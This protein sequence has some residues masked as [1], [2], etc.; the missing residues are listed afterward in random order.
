MT[1]FQKARAA[2]DKTRVIDWDFGD[3]PETVAITDDS[4]FHIHAYPGLEA[5]EDCA[6]LRLFKTLHEAQS[7]HRLGVMILYKLRFKEELAYLKKA[8][9]LPDNMKTRTSALGGSKAIEKIIFE[10]IIRDLFARSIKTREEFIHYA[11]TVEHKILPYGQEVLR[12]I[13]PV[14]KSYFET[15]KEFQAHEATHRMNA[16]ARKFLSELR[17]EL[18]RLMPPNF[19]EIYDNERLSHM[20]RYL[21]TF[22]LRAERGLLHLE[23]AFSKTAE[24]KIFADKLID[25]IKDLTPEASGEKKEAIEEFSQMLEEYKVSLFAQELK[26]AFPIS[27]KRLEEKI[28]EI[29]RME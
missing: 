9:Y 27:K 13:Q 2:W 17:C 3:I 23:K 11:Q 22:A 4:A 5:A 1:A 29:E 7:S 8:V 10:K 25:M 16:L 21:K 15:L 26:T 14:L 19:L 28:R 6:N 12:I 18:N 24:V 20:P